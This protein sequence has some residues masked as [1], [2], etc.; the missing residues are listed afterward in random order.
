MSIIV[1][2]TKPANL[3]RIETIRQQNRHIDNWQ[4][5]QKN[6]KFEKVGNWTRI[7]QRSGKIPNKVRDKEGNIDLRQISTKMAGVPK[8]HQGF[9]QIFR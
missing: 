4:F 3:A 6:G 8:I 7:R 1:G 5:S 9:G 2:F